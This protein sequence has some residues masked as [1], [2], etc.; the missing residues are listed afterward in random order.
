[1]KTNR[2]REFIAP[3]AGHGRVFAA[4]LALVLSA[5]CIGRAQSKPA[6]TPPA[7]TALDPAPQALPG[8]QA[9]PAAP[10]E[11][12]PRGG[13]DGITVH[14]H[15]TI[16]VK[17]PDGKLVSHR[18]FENGLLSGAV[19][20]GATLLSAFLGRAITPGSWW[21]EIRDP[22]ALQTIA[23]AE[24]SS[25]AEAGCKDIVPPKGGSFIC[26]ATPLSIIAPTLKSGGLAG[27]TLT[28][29]GSA[30]VPKGF[31]S[32]IGY[33][34]S[35]NFACAP[36]TSAQSCYDGSGLEN[37]FPLTAR[38]LTGATGTPTAPV[39][40]TPGQTVSVKVVIS[41]ASGN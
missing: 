33:V 18:E 9:G 19:G 8:V 7:A 36:S 17:N 28:L 15:W 13:D 23:I 3:V 2:K 10:G 26:S 31:P 27:S 1:V 35:D 20:G 12:Q 24:E 30:T 34:E 21:V 32:A 4:F 22:T 5:S 11:R 29:T 40:V 25:A 14:G 16:E 37:T 41:F 39:S 6:Q 38:F